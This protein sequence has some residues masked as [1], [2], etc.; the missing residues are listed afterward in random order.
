MKPIEERKNLT[1]EQFQTEIRGQVKPVVLRGLVSDWPVVKAATISPEACAAYISR[2]AGPE[3]YKI[4]V[5]PFETRGLLHYNAELTGL[6]FEWEHADVANFLQVLLDEGDFDNPRGLALQALRVASSLLGFE[7]VNPRPS[8]APPHANPHMWIGNALKIAT[9]SDTAENLA[10]VVAGKRRFTI[11]SPDQISNLY[12]GP[13]HFTP[14]GTPVSM[15]HLTAPDFEKYPKFAQALEHAQ[16]VDLLPGDALYLPFRW[17]HHVE[18]TEKFN[19]LLNYWWTDARPGI[20][21]ANAALNHALYSIGNMPP[22]QRA[23][24][25]EVFDHFVFHKY[26]DPWA[27]IPTHA[28]GALANVKDEDVAGIREGLIEQIKKG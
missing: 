25:R 1:F 2:F 20:G 13:L 12:I 7:D 24:W 11:F 5:A 3:Q 23:A 16:Y 22:E 15:V 10:C 14:A 9:H 6:N 18:A 26:G 28:R 4:G 19:I 27:H 17:Y 8:F 21:S